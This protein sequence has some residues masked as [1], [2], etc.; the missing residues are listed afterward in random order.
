MSPDMDL[1]TGEIRHLL[2]GRLGARNE[3]KRKVPGVWT[4]TGRGERHLICMNRGPVQPLSLRMVSWAES[5]LVLCPAMCGRVLSSDACS[6]GDRFL[7][8]AF[9]QLR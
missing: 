6:E 3:F 7:P 8:L 1:V 4:T 5:H 9:V 2:T